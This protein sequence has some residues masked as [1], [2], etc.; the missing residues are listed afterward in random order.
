MAAGSTPAPTQIIKQMSLPPDGS[1]EE[2]RAAETGA[3][4]SAS[5][6][7]RGNPIPVIFWIMIIAFVILSHAPAR[8]A[9][10]AIAA[11]R[12]GISPWVVLWGLNE[13]SRGSRGGWGGGGGPGAVAAAGAAA[14]AASPA[15]AA[16]SAAAARRA[17]GDAAFS[18]ADHAKVSAAI[19]AAE[20][21]SD[22]EI[23]AVA[24]PISDP[25]HD[26]ALH[27]ALSGAVRGARL[28][29]VAAGLR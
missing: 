19:A 6:P 12:G 15:A 16:R 8:R 17:H 27:W 4:A 21:K 14:A 23:V 26:V 28:G 1:A 18:D 3:A 7:G 9:A 11:R 2:R 13:L 5:A 10:G 29:R 25:Y 20:A 24:T 22:G